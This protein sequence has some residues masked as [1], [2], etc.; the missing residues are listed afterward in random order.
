MQLFVAVLFVVVL[1]SFVTGTSL[2]KDCR[3]KDRKCSY[4][5]SIG[6]CDNNP[7]YMRVSCCKS[8]NSCIDQNP[9]CRSWAMDGQCYK[10]RNYM[11]LKCCQSCIDYPRGTGV[12]RK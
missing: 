9:S 7:G 2:G 4:W 11:L 5:A 1:N 3:D 6:E 8:C 12:L 10:N